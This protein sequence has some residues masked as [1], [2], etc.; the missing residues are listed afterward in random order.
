[1]ISDS[2]SYE[3]RKI[4]SS[5]RLLCH[6]FSQARAVI[7]CSSL[8]PQ[9]PPLPTLIDATQ[10]CMTPNGQ[11]NKR[12]FP[13]PCGRETSSFIHFV[14][15]WMSASGRYRVTPSHSML[16]SH[17]ALRDS[18]AREKSGRFS[19]PLSGPICETHRRF[20]GSMWSRCGYPCR[21]Y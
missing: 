3:A 5:R 2:N 19:D 14:S 4:N 10:R 11:S 13:W 8:R 17:P 20:S 7:L 1:M 21:G 18:L 9:P 12:A 16:W 6:Q 15:L